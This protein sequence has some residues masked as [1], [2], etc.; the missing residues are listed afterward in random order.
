MPGRQSSKSNTPPKS[1]PAPSPPAP[2]P[3][4]PL[5]QS[6]LGP[7]MS[8]LPSYTNPSANSPSFFGIVKEGIAIGI[9]STLGNRI[10]SGI[11]GPPAVEI[12]SAAV[13]AQPTAAQPAPYAS[14]SSASPPSFKCD[15]QQIS[16]DTCIKD[17]KSLEECEEKLKILN[18]CLSK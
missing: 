4:A 6:P 14:S 7:S 2:S 15:S 8:N 12:K 1:S 13:P 9:G 5:F 18:E 11:F 10:V 17:P 3:R 16:F